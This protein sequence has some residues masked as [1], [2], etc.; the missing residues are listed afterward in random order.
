MT[1]STALAQE[2]ISDK[3]SDQIKATPKFI[4]LLENI[5]IQNDR[6]YRSILSIN[7]KLGYIS[8][9]SN[10]EQTQKS[11]TKESTPSGFVDSMERQIMSLA[12]KASDLENIVKQLDKL[13]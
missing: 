10:Q 13:I 7:E 9:Q 1:Y 11:E 8:Y 2:Q 3:S 5:S 4:Q 12:I 6:M